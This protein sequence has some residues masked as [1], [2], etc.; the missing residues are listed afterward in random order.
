M[1]AP[2][3]LL[4]LLLLPA[5]GSLRAGGNASETRIIGGREAAPHS[6]PYMVSLQQ[7]GTHL[8]GGVLVHPKWLDG[9]VRRSKTIQPLALPRGRHVVAAGAQ[10]SL[11]GWGLTQQGGH[12]AR[13]LRELDLRVLDARMCNNSRFWDGNVTPW[14]L[15]LQAPAKDQA[16]CKGDSGGPVVCKGRVAGILSFSSKACTDVFKPPVATAVAP[17]M[18]WIRKVLS[19]HRSPPQA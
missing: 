2:S 18:P 11:A 15:C 16:P 13:A 3:S 17:Y 14:M 12:L 9:K 1:E 19:R 5:L 6:R 7:A 8:C 10:C 4:L